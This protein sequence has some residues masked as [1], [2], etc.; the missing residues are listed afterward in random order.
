MRA[1]AERG[2]DLT[3]EFHAFDD[4]DHDARV[5]SLASHVL[6]PSRGIQAHLRPLRLA[7]M[8]KRSAFGNSGQAPEHHR[9]L[10]LASKRPGSL[11]SGQAGRPL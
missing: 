6:A 5:Q 8:V 7:P 2:A 9:G 3:A 10:S 1:A 4:V 11:L